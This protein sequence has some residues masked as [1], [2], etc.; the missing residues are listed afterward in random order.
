MGA[1]K[2]NFQISPSVRHQDFEHGDNFDN[3][4]FDRRDITQPGS[5]ID[6][7]TMA[8]RGQEPF[9]Q[10]TV[11]KFTDYA[12]AFMADFTF[13]DKLNLIAGA[14]YDYIDMESQDARGLMRA[15]SRRRPPTSETRRRGLGSL[16]YQLPFGLRP[17]VTKSKQSTLILGQGGQIPTGAVATATA[18]G[19]SELEEN[20]IKAS[21]STT[22][23]ISRGDYFKQE[24]LDYN[25]QDT[26]T[27]NTTEAKGYEFEA[28]WVVNRYVTLTGAYTRIKV[29]QHWR[30]R[31][32]ESRYRIRS[33][34]PARGTCRA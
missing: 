24:R 10:H 1:V 9:S 7:R 14:R 25:A 27:N 26:V 4:Y 34:S 20:G 12:L 30:S 23:C 22:S 8:T 16:S 31:S 32:G 17:Y 28:R 19:D 11:G 13:F 3:E 33:A 2:A 6:R 18:V 15:V 21:C 5:P 29:L